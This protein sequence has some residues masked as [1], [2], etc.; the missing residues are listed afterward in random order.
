M[1]RENF[2][3]AFHVCKRA[4]ICLVANQNIFDEVKLF[5]VGVL[6]H[7]KSCLLMSFQFAEVRNLSMM[8]EVRASI[9]T[10]VQIN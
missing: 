10:G 9:E 2:A 1:A 8:S 5:N 7:S 4:S 6:L 3:S